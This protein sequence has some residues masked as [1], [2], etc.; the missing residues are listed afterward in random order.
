LVGLKALSFL[1]IGWLFGPILTIG[2]YAMC[3]GLPYALA[4]FVILVIHEGGHWVWMKALGLEPN[5]PVFLPFIAYV[6]MTKL[7]PD[8]ATRAW[9]AYAGPLVGGLGSVILFWFGVQNHNAW[10]MAAGNTGF[11]LNLFQLVPARPFDGGFIIQ[12]I[13]KWLL[14]PGLAILITLTVLFRSPLLMIISIISV[15]SLF[16]QFAA[17]STQHAGSGKKLGHVVERRGGAGLR[18]PN[19]FYEKESQPP[20][21]AQNHSVLASEV[22]VDDSGS[23]IIHPATGGQRVLIALAYIILASGLA[24]LYWLSSNEL[25]VFQPHHP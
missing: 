7:P 15:I 18:P 24:W 12:A 13:S 20:L 16:G 1:K 19:P 10:M 17:K 4:I 14:I 9:V 2:F 5:M 25:T 6:R 11:F 22:S 21:P 3:Y 23:L 8:E